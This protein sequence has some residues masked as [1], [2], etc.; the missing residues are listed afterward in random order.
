MYVQQIQVVMLC[1]LQLS[2]LNRTPQ[3][4]QL[5]IP[6]CT[7]KHTLTNSPTLTTTH[8]TSLHTTYHQTTHI[9]T[10][11]SR[12]RYYEHIWC[13]TVLVYYS[14]CTNPKRTSPTSQAI[15]NHVTE[16]IGPTL[17]TLESV[18]IKDP[19]NTV[20]LNGNARHVPS[21]YDP[22]YG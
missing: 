16:N 15:T 4:K 6:H 18:T 10:F 11:T 7:H 21:W 17:P 14:I 22:Q 13:F 9:H 1:I 8:N 19:S 2:F 20:R 3:H 5:I 12:T